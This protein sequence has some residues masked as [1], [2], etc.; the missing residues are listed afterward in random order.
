MSIFLFY[1]SVSLIPSIVKCSDSA[2][3]STLSGL[4][5]YW[6]LNSN[7]FDQLGNADLINPNRT[8]FVR[9]RK[10]IDSAAL[11]INNGYVDISGGL[12]FGTSFSI[13]AW[14]N[15]RSYGNMSRL[16]DCGTTVNGKENII[17]SISF[18]STA[19]GF[20]ETNTNYKS[21][22]LIDTF[23]SFTIGQWTHVAFTLQ[24]DYAYIYFNGSL[25]IVGR[26]NTPNV[27]L[28]RTCSIGKSWNKANP[29]ANMYIDD[30]MIFNTSLSSSA[31]KK[32]MK[33]YSDFIVPTSTPIMEITMP[34]TT[35]LQTTT[36][37]A[38][39]VNYWKF[40]NDFSDNVTSLNLTASTTSPG[41]IEFYADRRGRA[42]SVVHLEGGGY[43]TTTNVFFSGDFS[44]VLWIKPVTLSSMMVVFD[45]FYQSFVFQNRMTLYINSD[46]LI[47]SQINNVDNTVFAYT[48]SNYALPVRQWTHVGV[49]LVGQLANI[50]VNG[51]IDTSYL[52]EFPVNLSQRTLCYF[53]TYLQSYSYYQSPNFNYYLMANLD[54][55][56][57]FNRGLSAFEI[58][59]VMNYYS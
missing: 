44:T 19:N 36:L 14:V 38:G 28:R 6:N 51:S 56:M 27:T 12:S 20:V 57:F 43:L 50:Y 33:F 22:R 24:N 37:P 40:N 4:I 32:A 35:S 26:L 55:I 59:T 58:N 41:V 45:V 34:I 39:L 7:L 3:P 10:G 13:S 52:V 29:L 31:V 47:R 17:I 18:Q 5:H 1:L 9:D 46:G 23:S 42:N 2:D 25:D 30:L 54:D 48:D 15:I 8:S 11:F 53:G 16:I 21:S 49:T